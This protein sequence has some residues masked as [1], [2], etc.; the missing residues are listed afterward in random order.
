[1]K[2]NE[3]A[4]RQTSI[5]ARLAGLEAED[6]VLTPLRAIWRRELME[7]RDEVVADGMGM[8]DCE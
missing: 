7:K 8:M 5:E 6:A 2:F 1:M 4:S 3:I